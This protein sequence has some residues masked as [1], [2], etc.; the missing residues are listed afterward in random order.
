MVYMKRTLTVIFTVF[1]LIGFNFIYISDSTTEARFDN[2]DNIFN[3]I[4]E[5]DKWLDVL[6]LIK[7]NEGFGFWVKNEGEWTKD[8]TVVNGSVVTL[9]IDRPDLPLLQTYMEM[10]VISTENIWEIVTNPFTDNLSLI[11]GAI[12]KKPVGLDYVFGSENCKPEFVK[13]YDYWDKMD[14]STLRNNVLFID[15]S[16]FLQ[17]DYDIPGYDE[18]FVVVNCSEN[19]MDNEKLSKYPHCTQSADE[20]DFDDLKDLVFTHPYFWGLDGGIN[21]LLMHW[22]FARAKTCPEEVTFKLRTVKTGDWTIGAGYVKTSINFLTSS[23][24]CDW[25]NITVVDPLESCKIETVDECLIG[26]SVRFNANVTQGVAPYKYHWDFGDGSTSSEKN[27]KHRFFKHGFFNVSLTVT[28]STGVTV[29]DN[30]NVDVKIAPLNVG[31]NGPEQDFVGEYINFYS[32]VSGGLPPYD[33]VWDFGDGNMS[34][35]EDVTHRYFSEGIFDVTLSVTD[36]NNTAIV[37]HHSLNLSVAPLEFNAFFPKVGFVGESINFSNSV[38]GGIPPYRY[39]WDFGDGN[40]SNKSSTEFIYHDDGVYNVTLSVT[41]KNNTVVNKTYP[42]DIRVHPLVCNIVE[43]VLVVAGEPYKF[44]VDISGGIPPYSFLWDFGDGS[45]VK[46]QAVSYAYKTS[47]NYQVKFTVTDSEYRAANDT[48]NLRV[49]SPNEKLVADAGEKY[50]GF[51]GHPVKF[52]GSKS[53]DILDQGLTYHWD[54]GD[55]ET[56]TGVTCNHIFRYEGIYSVMLTV[57]NED[58]DKNTDVTT[59]NVIKDTVP[60]GDIKNIE[61]L[62]AKDGVVN[63]TWDNAFDNLKVDYYNVYRDSCLIDTTKNNFY[64]DSGLIDNQKYAYQ[65]EAVDVFGNIGNKSKNVFATPI[66]SNDP[67]VAIAGGPYH[68]KTG[69]IL[70]FDG[71]NSSD[72]K[73]LD[74]FVWDFGDG[75]KGTGEIVSNIYKNKGIY[76][77]S[78][79]VTDDD[80]ES[81]VD[82]T[83]VVVTEGDKT[84]PCKPFF[85]GMI[86]GHKAKEMF[87]DIGLPCGYDK[88]VLYVIDWDD[89]SKK[90]TK[91]VSADEKVTVS[92][93]WNSSGVFNVKVYA[94]NNVNLKSE[95]LDFNVLI[96]SIYVGSYGFLVDDDAD[97][98]YDSFYNNETKTYEKINK[99]DENRYLLD[100]DDDGSFD[101]I[102]DSTKSSF[103]SYSADKEKDN[104]FILGSIFT[105][106]LIIFMMSSLLVLGYL[107]YEKKPYYT[108]MFKNLI[109]FEHDTVIINPALTAKNSGSRIEGVCPECSKIFVGDVIKNQGYIYSRCSH[110][111]TVLK[112][113]E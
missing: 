18:V 60:P 57:E 32:K 35:N 45:K 83:Y 14:E 74:D 56:G 39:H 113:K 59:V 36:K 38:S 77:I 33:F 104:G 2:I 43:P 30:S 7:N 13:E 34:N 20:L 94:E 107:F 85:E 62:D 102:F 19:E 75:T 82:K 48:L 47:G 44:E 103:S 70:V 99:V 61:V 63:L 97:S 49:I 51:V 92:H 68:C 25:F 65:I 9:K 76:S 91:F 110:C 23:L 80:G 24:G 46:K 55:G 106:V 100:V 41:D 90:S 66:E 96:D 37:K 1:F 4:L 95:L 78:L 12:S 28:D 40:S 8:I 22:E 79:K 29:A 31:M 71:S 64:K 26:E 16:T 105:Y 5:S 109:N 3:N 17:E 11:K 42:I 15:A 50:T 21:S 93:I 88:N 27:P 87:F 89:G 86:N 72:D 84:P 54:F 67:P 112:K 81:N 108:K 69:E 101:Y 6:E 52:N 111:E 58:G 53:K 73:L 98:V 10:V